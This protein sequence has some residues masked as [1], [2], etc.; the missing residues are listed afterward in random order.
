M[1]EIGRLE[2]DG[3]KA[4]KV[5]SFHRSD[6]RKD[7]LILHAE[8]RQLLDTIIPRIKNVGEIRKKTAQIEIETQQLLMGVA[9][10][11]KLPGDCINV[12]QKL[13]LEPMTPSFDLMEQLQQNLMKS[14][15]TAEVVRLKFKVDELLEDKTKLRGENAV[16]VDEERKSKA[17]Y[18]QLKID[19]KQAEDDLTKERN[20]AL[21]EGVKL[22]SEVDNLQKQ[23]V[24]LNVSVDELSEKLT[25][26]KDDKKR[27]EKDVSA[28]IREL[29]QL[30]DGT[31]NMIPLTVGLN[32]MMADKRELEK[33][34]DRLYERIGT[35]RDGTICYEL[36]DEDLEKAKKGRIVYEEEREKSK[37][38]VATLKNRKIDCDIADL[39]KVRQEKNTSEGGRDK[40]KA[41]VEE[42]TTG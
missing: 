27:S 6:C 24:E 41:R 17:R 28:V 23:N 19:K 31:L 9:E 34:R 12:L 8:I 36:T 30:T 42:L 38:H 5:Y 15:Q 40:Q 32:K 7:A 35:L 22:R 2:I 25:R 4:N 21:D 3:G 26:M 39:D 10:H 37:S 11:H 20:R 1:F 14:H 13:D 33:Q 29:R 16:F 18:R